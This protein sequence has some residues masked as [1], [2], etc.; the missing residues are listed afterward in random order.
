MEEFD[1][2]NK[3]KVNFEEECFL[4]KLDNSSHST[5]CS[6]VAHNLE[7][8]CRKHT[9][10]RLKLEWTGNRHRCGDFA[11]YMPRRTRMT[12]REKCW[13][14]CGHILLSVIVLGEIYHSYRQR[15]LFLVRH[16]NDL[17]VPTSQ[18]KRQCCLYTAL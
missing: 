16:C 6:W 10:P 3:K 17:P 4:H 2:R 18:K 9:K 14:S 1:T 13:A 12:T 15:A 11:I 5:A 8:F 7:V